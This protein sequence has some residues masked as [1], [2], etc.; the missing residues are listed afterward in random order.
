MVAQLL[1]THQSPPSHDNIFHEDTKEFTIPKLHKDALQG[2]TCTTENTSPRSHK[3]MVKDPEKTEDKTSS[4]HEKTVKDTNAILKGE[5]ALQDEMRKLK[6]DIEWRKL[7]NKRLNALFIQD[8]R[9]DA[10]PSENGIIQD[11]QT[12]CKKVEKVAWDLRK[13]HTGQL[14]HGTNG[15]NFSRRLSRF[16]AS[17]KIFDFLWEEVFDKPCF[18][19]NNDLEQCL[20]RFEQEMYKVN[21]RYKIPS[22][23]S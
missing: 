16:T 6:E 12:L 1:E 15:K 17:Q 14:V 7:E 3:D 22:F 13:N 21:S 20:M 2:A 5:A 11:Y 9:P 4:L 19:L 18:G 10:E 23:A 8:H